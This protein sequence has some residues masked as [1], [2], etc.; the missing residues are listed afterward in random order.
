MPKSVKKSCTAQTSISRYFNTQKP[1]EHQLP[2]GK[3]RSARARSDQINFVSEL[4]T[5]PDCFS[6]LSAAK[7]FLSG[8]LWITSKTS[9]TFPPRPEGEGGSGQWDYILS[10]HKRWMQETLEVPLLS[11]M[12]LQLDI[13]ASLCRVWHQ[14]ESMS[15]VED[16]VKSTQASWLFY[17]WKTSKVVE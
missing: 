2:R 14:K 12:L 5:Q 7:S 3:V 13:W 11:K 15:G 10:E 4:I 16:H 1:A 9:Q 6:A 8:W 17:R